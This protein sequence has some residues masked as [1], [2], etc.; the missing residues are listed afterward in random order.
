MD[1]GIG[2][3]ATDQSPT[4]A[5]CEHLALYGAAPQYGEPDTREIWDREEAMAGLDQ[6]IRLLAHSVAPDGLQL[7]DERENLLWGFVNTLHAQMQRLDRAVDKLMPELR[8]LERGQDGTEINSLELE[9]L[10]QRAQNL[11][12][13]RDAFE[14]L[15]D[16]AADGYNVETGDTWRPR[17]GSHTSINRRL[18][19]AAI[20]ARD[21]VRARKDR[22]TRAHLPDGTL[23]A[24]AGGKHVENVDI[25]W[26]TLDQVRAKYGDMVLV[27]GGSDGVEKLAARWAETRGVDQIVCKPDW[28]R[29]N[30]AAPFKRNDEMLN[31]LPKGIVAFPGSGITENLI[32]KARKLGIPVHR[33]AA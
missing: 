12:D 29:H 4:A 25:I 17:H 20:E 28:N 10:T 9:T 5:V 1:N 24:I 11:G 26:T 18:T 21:F 27:H 3:I 13:R 30:R 22:E 31:L 19:S 32:D 6:V 15:R 7:A 16:L 2:N 8:E 23:I 33:V 14:T